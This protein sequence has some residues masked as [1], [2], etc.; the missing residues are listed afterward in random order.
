MPV[1]K[2]NDKKE[3]KDEIKIGNISLNN[4]IKKL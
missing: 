4:K 1:K 3:E 2:I